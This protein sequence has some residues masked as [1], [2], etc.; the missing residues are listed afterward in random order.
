MV[1]WWILDASGTDMLGNNHGSVVG[2]PSF[3]TGHVGRAVVFDSNDDGITI[4]HDPSLDVGPSGFT[5]EFWMRGTKNQPHGL[6][7]VVDKSHG[8]VDS[9][10]WLFQGNS[11]TGTIGVA[12]GAGPPGT[13]NF[14]GLSSVVDVLDGVYHHICGT[15]N[16]TQI[17]LFVD[18]VSQGSFP[19]A[20]PVNN[21]RPVNLGFSYGG[22][23]ALR[24]FRG[25][26][27][28][29]SVYSRALS[30]VE[31]AAIANAGA[32]GKCRPPASY[33]F[34][35]GS[36]VNATGYNCTSNPVIGTNW[37]STIATTPATQMTLLA[38]GTLVGQTPFLGGE[39]LF[40]ISAPVVVLQGTGTHSVPIPNLLSLVGSRLAT[41]GIRADLIGGQLRIAFLNAQDV[42]IGF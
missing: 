8:W 32:A 35:N 31:I 4:P 28:E 22:S 12:I 2:T 37:G 14:P 40:D 41:Q 11:R 42:L 1:S 36:G 20:A 10:G 21:T 17:E 27:D 6:Y 39:I 25:S 16:G 29:L 13:S 34:R 23:S 19:L 18:G 5:A 24:F 26:V 3:S 33:T 30:V 38:V 15:W 9:T 7:L